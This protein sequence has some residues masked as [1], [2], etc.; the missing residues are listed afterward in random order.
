MQKS[1]ISFQQCSFFFVIYAFV[2]CAIDSG[3]NGCW[4]VIHSADLEAFLTGQGWFSGY[5]VCLSFR[6]SIMVYSIVK[7]HFKITFE[8]FIFLLIWSKTYCLDV[9]F[10]TF[11]NLVLHEDT[12]GADDKCYSC[13][14]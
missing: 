5:W 1:L 2:G 13:L 11:C 8:N 7:I 3:M 9:V 4:W 10:S 12:E 14:P 6:K